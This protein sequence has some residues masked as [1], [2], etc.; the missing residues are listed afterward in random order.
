LAS[1]RFLPVGESISLDRFGELIEVIDL[2]EP[3][4]VALDCSLLTAV[5]GGASCVRFRYREAGQENGVQTLCVVAIDETGD[6]DG[7]T[8]VSLNL[9]TFLDADGQL[10]GNANLLEAGD[11]R[12]YAVCRSETGAYRLQQPSDA[13]PPLYLHVVDALGDGPYSLGD[14]EFAAP[15]DAAIATY[16]G[17]A[18][19]PP[20]I[21]TVSREIHELTL[22]AERFVFNA[23]DCD[24]V[25]S[26]SSSAGAVL[27]GDLL[28]IGFGV[29]P[30]EVVEAA[31]A[32]TADVLDDYFR[33][34]TGLEWDGIAGNPDL[35][36]RVLIRLINLDV[37]DEVVAVFDEQCGLRAKSVPVAYQVHWASAYLPAFCSPDGAEQARCQQIEDALA[38]EEARRIGTVRAA[39]YDLWFAAAIN[40]REAG[41]FVSYEDELRPHFSLFAGVLAN[42]QVNPSVAPVDVP[43]ALAGAI[44]VFATEVGPATSVLLM[45][46]G[47]PITAQTEGGFC[48]ADICASDFRG[49]FDQ[50]EAWPGAAI[51]H[52]SSQQFVGFGVAIFD[53]SHFDI[54]EPYEQFSGFPLNRAGETGY[55]NPVLNIYRAQ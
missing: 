52:L 49:A 4:A 39:G 10:A 27:P 36:M 53:G 37:L 34:R 23:E 2:T 6:C 41:E 44:E 13:L 15:R 20:W 1:H 5:A 45:L 48:E 9:E 17:T 19:C 18:L 24:A 54:R 22:T 55:N 38:A 40:F 30:E 25:P 11:G 33:A 26:C 46:S 47:G 21:V 12:F 50:T 28:R 16:G 14:D 31:R 35:E 51:D 32:A 3:P 43:A 7:L 29:A 8:R 42:P